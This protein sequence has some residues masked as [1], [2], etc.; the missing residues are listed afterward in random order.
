MDDFTDISLFAPKT[1]LVALMTEAYETGFKAC[2]EMIADSEKQFSKRWLSERKAKEMFGSARLKN[3][4]EDGD[5]VPQTTGNGR[6]SKKMYD[7]KRL[8]TL[9]ATETIKIRKPLIV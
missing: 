9:D 3:W 8:L 2:M 1:E 7:Y 6:N 5:I 4:V